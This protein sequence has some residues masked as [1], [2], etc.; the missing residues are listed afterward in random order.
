M[1]GDGFDISDHEI[2]T[3]RAPTGWLDNGLRTR[4]EQAARTLLAKKVV[5]QCRVVKKMR[6]NG[7][8]EDVIFFDGVFFK[9]SLKSIFFVS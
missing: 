2:A 8:G 6:V 1:I 9:S 5:D 3:V 4:I 7:R